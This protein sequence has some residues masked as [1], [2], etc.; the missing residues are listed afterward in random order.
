M[1][2]DRS[3]APWE[4]AVHAELRPADPFEMAAAMLGLGAALSS[5]SRQPYRSRSRPRVK[6]EDPTV[7]HKKQAQRAARKARRRGETR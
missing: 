4:T 7:K 3:L 2:G 1:V 5:L 6:A